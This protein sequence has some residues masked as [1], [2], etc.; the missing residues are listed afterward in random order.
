MDFLAD[1]GGLSAILGVV[2]VRLHEETLKELIG[3]QIAESDL[4][5]PEKIRLL[6]QLKSLPAEAIKHLSL[7]LIDA[8]LSHWSSAL[9][10]IEQF[11]H[12]GGS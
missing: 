3:T 2:T 1:D 6:D 9:P 7:K 4:P 5:D 10:V 11:V 8:G 12:R